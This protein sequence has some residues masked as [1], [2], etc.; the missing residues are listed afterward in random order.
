LH[1]IFT[2]CANLLLLGIE[3]LESGLWFLVANILHCSPR[4][5]RQHGRIALKNVFS[6]SQEWS[7]STQ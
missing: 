1:T 2:G 6:Q 4:E 7:Y 5:I 3:P